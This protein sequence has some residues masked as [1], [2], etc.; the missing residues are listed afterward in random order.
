MRRG[1]LL[2]VL[3]A[4]GGCSREWYRRDA[5]RETYH[6]L[7]ERRQE[8]VWPIANDG[9]ERP[10]ASRLYDPFNPNYPPMPPDDPAAD[11]YM[12]RVYYARLEELDFPRRRRFRPC[13]MQTT[14]WLK[15]SNSTRTANWC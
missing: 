13:P 9:I 7:D 14:D 2:L 12:R 6:I 15:G 5:D 11:Q 3:I 8:A 1:L 4:L 10:P